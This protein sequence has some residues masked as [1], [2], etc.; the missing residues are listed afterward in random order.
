MRAATL[1]RVTLASFSFL[2]ISDES[3][4]PTYL[5]AQRTPSPNHVTLFDLPRSRCS[6][7]WTA[8][9]RNL[10]HWQWNKKKKAFSAISSISLPPPCCTHT[11]TP[12][13]TVA[14]HRCITQ[15]GTDVPNAKD[16]R[17]QAPPSMRS[18]PPRSLGTTHRSTPLSPFPLTLLPPTKILATSLAQM[19]SRHRRASG[20][21]S[22]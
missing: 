21:S 18:T 17:A 8:K 13:S 10:S 15:K 9:P 2:A 3:I 1:S 14:Y 7:T 12:R 6:R 22:S 5:S 16:T 11:H 4:L 20:P 19:A